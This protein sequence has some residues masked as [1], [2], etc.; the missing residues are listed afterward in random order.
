M[1]QWDLVLVTGSIFLILLSLYIIAAKRNNKKIE[2]G[3]DSSS[4]SFSLNLL[5]FLAF[6]FFL[7]MLIF[8]IRPFIKYIYIR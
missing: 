7:F 8:L 6:V 3:L 1:I 4:D 5:L 2:N